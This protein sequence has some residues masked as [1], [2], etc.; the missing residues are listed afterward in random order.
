MIQV[1]K[2]NDMQESKDYG[3]MNK[4]LKEMD[5]KI[6]IIDIKYGVSCYP[7]DTEYGWHTQYVSGAL[8]IYKTINNKEA[9]KDPT[10]VSEVAMQKNT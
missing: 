7:P 1:K 5:E 2:F 6:E 4:W 3:E 10:K 8:V 9:T